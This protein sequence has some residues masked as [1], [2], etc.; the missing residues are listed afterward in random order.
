MIKKFIAALFILTLILSISAYSKDNRAVKEAIKVK[1]KCNEI[2]KSHLV[3]KVTLI[4]KAISEA[5]W[6]D[7]EV[8]NPKKQ[9]QFYTQADLY[10]YK[11]KLS[12]VFI[13]EDS[14]SGDESRGMEYFFRED[15]TIACIDCNFGSLYGSV[16]IKTNIYYNSKGKKAKEQKL[17]YDYDTHK[18]LDNKKI[19]NE[20]FKWHYPEIYLTAKSILKELKYSL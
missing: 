11:N 20:D 10:I 18:P 9:V 14:P 16:E 3:K 1:K 17:I 12:S 8:L 13:T 7:W 5:Q 4:R 19:N 2:K 6:G 15:G